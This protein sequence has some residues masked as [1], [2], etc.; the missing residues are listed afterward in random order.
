MDATALAERARA[1]FEAYLRDGADGLLP[2]LTPDVVW[3]DDPEWPDSQVSRG[4]DEVRRMLGAR[5]ESTEIT[6][7]L[8]HVEARGTRALLLMVWTAEG[9]G[10]GAVA[11]LRPAVVFDYEG[12]S[13]ARIR[14]FLDRERARAVLEDD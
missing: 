5:L 11:E 6:A 4:H 8:E 9:Q 14:F 12:E 13:V 2:H 3:E 1:G 10:S 7:E